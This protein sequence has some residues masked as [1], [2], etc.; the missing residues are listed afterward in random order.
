MKFKEA[1]HDAARTL[2][3]G[4]IEAPLLEAELLLMH[5]MEMGR[6]ELYVKLEDD[7]PLRYSDAL[8]ELVDRRLKREPSAYILGHREFYGLDFYVG[9]GVLIPRPETETL[10]DAAVAF[11]HS[12]F[13]WSDPVIADIGT[14]SG[15][16]AVSLAHLFPRAKVYAMDMSRQALDIAALNCIRHGVRVEILQGDLLA[17]LPRSV[18]IIVANLPYVRNDEM[19]G[20]P[21]EI[22]DY[23]PHIALSG[24][25]DGLDIVR[26][27]IVDAGEKLRAGGVVLIEIAPSQ[28][29]IFKAWIARSGLWPCVEPVYDDGG[30]VRV[31]KLSW[32]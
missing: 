21:E 26:R 12:N 14:G 10:V 11:I 3:E 32:I 20:L 17:P 27:L 9:P 6:T 19:A 28:V 1:L 31:L 25:A 16:V 30:I 5:A 18:D 7:L 22:R 4:S 24:G 13:L 29:D 23:E 8:L 2:A 15:A